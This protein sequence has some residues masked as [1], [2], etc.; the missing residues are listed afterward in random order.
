MK[1]QFFTLRA[2]GPIYTRE[3]GAEGPGRL[4]HQNVKTI[5]LKICEIQT[6]RVIRSGVRVLANMFIVT[7][8]VMFGFLFAV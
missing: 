2:A 1:V 4:G 8:F 3:D 5:S 6:Q 7:V